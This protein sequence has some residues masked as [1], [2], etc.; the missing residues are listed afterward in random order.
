M[1]I[2]VAVKRAR[3]G[4]N[5]FSVEKRESIVALA[6]SVD[7]GLVKRADRLA[8]SSNKF[9]SWLAKALI[10]VAIIIVSWRAVAAD[11]FNSDVFRFAD[12]LSTNSAVVLVRTLAGNDGAGLSVLII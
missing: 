1:V 4:V 5:A 9:E 3:S 2:K 7:V 6:F 10:G 12:A 11:S 8:E